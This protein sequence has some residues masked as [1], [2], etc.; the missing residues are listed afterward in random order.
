MTSA[1]FFAALAGPAAW[2][3]RPARA[4][5]EESWLPRLQDAARDAVA[6]DGPLLA[7]EASPIHPMRIYG[8][9]AGMLD[10]DAVVIGDGGDFVSY[11]GKYIEPGRP[12][13]VARPGPVRL[14]GHRA[15]LRDR[16]PDRPARRPRW[17]CCSGT[18]RP[19][20]R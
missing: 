10:D 20:S 11:A 6:A 18:A 14:P 17:C 19:G 3:G 5:W 4:A 12:G 2:P 9:L 7:S 16:G 8:E 15:G 13:R 1:R